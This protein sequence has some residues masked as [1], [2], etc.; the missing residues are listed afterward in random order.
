MIVPNWSNDE[1]LLNDVGVVLRACPAEQ[2]AIG[3][4]RSV[5]A[6]RSRD[7][8]LERAALRYDSWVDADAANAQLRGPADAAPR[9][10]VFGHETGGLELELGGA[11]IEG[12]LVPPV[13]GVVTLRMLRGDVVERVADS[14]GCFSF[15]APPGGPIRFEWATSEST[16]ATMWIMT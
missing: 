15:P 8:G 2:L 6:W 16:F 5:F 4:A 11:G 9:A 14:L 3:A 1:E 13:P 12:Q 10:L 7:A